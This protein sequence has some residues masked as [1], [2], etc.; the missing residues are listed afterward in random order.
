M[1]EKGAQAQEPEKNVI[2]SSDLDLFRKYTHSDVQ[3][4]KDLIV[5]NGN[6]VKKA[7]IAYITE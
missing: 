5:R 6:D 2:K 3:T 7:L 1:S 4:A